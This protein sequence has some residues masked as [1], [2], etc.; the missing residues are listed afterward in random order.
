LEGKIRGLEMSLNGVD[1]ARHDSNDCIIRISKNRFS[2]QSK[3][4]GSYLV[5]SGMGKKS[6]SPITLQSVFI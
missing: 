5:F 6:F 4:Q 1:L 3:Q 2:E